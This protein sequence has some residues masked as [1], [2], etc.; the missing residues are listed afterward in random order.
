MLAV[1]GVGEGCGRLR[2]ERHVPA[3]YLGDV[4]EV[5]LKIFAKHVEW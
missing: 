2:K 1:G 3:L 5:W 4:V